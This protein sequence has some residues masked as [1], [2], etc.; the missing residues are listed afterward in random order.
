M[1]ICSAQGVSN[2]RPL[3]YKT[4]ALATELWRQLNLMDHNGLI[5]SDNLQ[6]VKWCVPTTVKRD[7]VLLEDVSRVKIVV[8]TLKRDRT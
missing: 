6:T 5:I 1:K 4:S 3:L 2:S 8:D 7:L